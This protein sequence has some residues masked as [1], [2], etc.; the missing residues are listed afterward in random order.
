MSLRKKFTGTGIAIVTPFHADGT[1]DWDSFKKLIQFWIEGKTEYLVK[2]KGFD[3]SENSWEPIENL[4][5]V[6]AVVDAFEREMSIANLHLFILRY[7][8]KRQS[9]P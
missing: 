5:N 3:E 2:W 1:I 8:L 4:K 6:H 7:W 9:E